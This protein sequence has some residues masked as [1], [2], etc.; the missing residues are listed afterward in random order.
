MHGVPTEVMIRHVVSNK[1]TRTMTGVCNI[2]GPTKIFKRS[3]DNYR[4]VAKQRDVKQEHMLTRYG[5][6]ADEYRELVAKQKGRC[7]ICKKKPTVL[8]VDHCH[9][10]RKVRGLLCGTCNR[11]LGMFY[12]DPLLMEL[13]A[14]YVTLR[15]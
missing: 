12:D 2:C 4:C 6:T 7:A 14:R 15:T 3:R 5:I 1:N 10:S 8:H 13:A 11:G 9:N